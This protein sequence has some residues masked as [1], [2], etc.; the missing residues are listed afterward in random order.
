MWA[1]E[2]KHGPAFVG[3]TGLRIPLFQAHFTPCVEIGWRLAYIAARGWQAYTRIT[4]RPQHLSLMIDL[5]C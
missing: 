3:Y 4:H 1:V 5:M 2:V